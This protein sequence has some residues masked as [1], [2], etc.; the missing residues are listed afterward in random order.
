MK[1]LIILILTA[2]LFFYA[3]GGSGQEA[4]KFTDE[5]NLIN[6]EFERLIIDLQEK[7]HQAQNQEEFNLLFK[8]MT[9]K[10]EKKKESIKNLLI[11]YADKKSSDE[12]ELIRSM[13]LEEIGEFDQ[14]IEKLDALISRSSPLADQAVFEKVKIALARDEY[15][16]ALELFRGIEE[17]IAPDNHKFNVYMALAEF[18]TEA[19]IRREFAEKF[20]AAEELPASMHNLKPRMLFILAELA[21]DEGEID[22]A[23][24][25]LEQA[26]ETSN[27]ERF[28]K[29][30]A[31]KIKQ[32]AII[33]QPAPNLIAE[34]WLNTRPLALDKLKG[35]AVIIDFWAPWC[36]PCR[37]VIPFLVE[38]YDL[39]KD[40]GLVVIGYTK[41][42]GRYVDDQ[43][44]IPQ[45]KP[46]EEIELIKD[47]VARH[48]IDYPVA[49]AKEGTGFDEYG[50]TAI[51]TMIL[52]DRQGNVDYIKIGSGNEESLKEKIRSLLK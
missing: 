8:E 50:I 49:I 22:K 14:A 44:N 7:A 45:V 24:S 40:Q 51:P 9:E 11:Q 20:L 36:P 19:E 43:K 48:D 15:S 6:R 31:S 29:S 23:K 2:C 33:N 37:K 25:L 12:M 21:I 4:A 13:A 38:T 46:D 3:C 39:Y 18:S 16:Q 35:K 30:A 27:D 26:K 1:P 34:T 32:L 52:V 17:R 10:Q 28:K 41:L 47:F 5:L 42:Y